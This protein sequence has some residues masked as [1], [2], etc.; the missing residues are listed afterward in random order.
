MHQARHQFKG[1]IAATVTPFTAGGEVNEAAFRK[2]LE[3]N[4]GAGI[5]GFWVT[6]GTGEGVYLGDDERIRMA[7]VAVDQVKGRAKVIAHVGTFTTRSA[8]RI[9]EGARKAGVDAVSSV[10]PMFYR[11]GDEATIGHYRAIGEATG[12][13]LFIYNIPHAT[14]VE[15][16]PP[17][18]EK[19]IEA[20]PQLAGVKHSVHNLLNLRAF[21]RMGLTVF[22]GF[23]EVLLPAMTMG[24]VGTVDGFPNVFPEPFVET[25][26][27]FVKGDLERAVEAQERANRFTDLIWSAPFSRAYHH[28]FKVVLGARLGIDLGGT[29]APLLELTGEEKRDLLQR[30][31]ELGA[32]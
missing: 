29:R 6:G 26:S 24:A 27:A 13:P 18:M 2:V 11:P 30:A 5:D 31:K 19:L 25:Y 8:A 12:L 1:V 22:T 4:I 28:A 32:L 15:V 14:G 20:V 21:A 9:A 17:L 10:P 16:V 3:F 7:E 23:S